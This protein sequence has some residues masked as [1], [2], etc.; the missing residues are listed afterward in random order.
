M[1]M[2]NGFAIPGQQ[3]QDLTKYGSSWE[4]CEINNKK[5]ICVAI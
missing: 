1:M 5:Y 2:L 4:A 3:D